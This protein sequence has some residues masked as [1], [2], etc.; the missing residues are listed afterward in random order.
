MDSS[1]GVG[2]GGAPPLRGGLGEHARARVAM[3]TEGTYPFVTGGVSTWCDQ[4]I[5]GLPEHD[6]EIVSV[7]ATDG[8]TPVWDLPD[9]V[10]AVRSVV[11]WGYRPPGKAPV[12]AARTDFLSAL[13]PFLRAVL[14][15]DVDDDTF[16]AGLM[17]L[18]DYAQEASLTAALMSDAAAELL[19][20]LWQSARGERVTVFEVLKALELLEHSLRPLSAPAISADMCHATS[21]G[22]PSL[23]ALIAKWRHGTPFIMSE[24]GVYLRERYL[25]FQDFDCPWSVKFVVL[26]FF[27]R[28]SRIAYAEAA[29]IAPVN[30]YNQRWEV[31]CG[32]DPDLIITALNGVDVDK[33]PVADGE[34]DEQ[35]VAWVGRVDPLKDLETLVDAFARLVRSQP[36]ARLDL[37]GPTPAGNESYR[38]RVDE[39]VQRRH[40]QDSVRFMGPVSPV[41]TAYH[42]SRVVVLSSISEGLPYTVIEAMMC[43]RATVSTDVGG[44]REVVGDAGLLVPPRD[45][46]ALATALEMVLTDDAL[47]HGLAARATE[48]GRSFFRLE[49]M[50]GT[51]RSE[52]AR[53]IRPQLAEFTPWPSSVDL[54]PAQR[55]DLSL[56]LNVATAVTS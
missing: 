44:V 13:R 55:S 21:N 47:R 54:V 11:L 56:D 32:A 43:G 15:S 48:R 34:P 49:Q 5:R 29:V 45:P 2:A 3:I 35:V 42:R 6:F 27:R 16:V 25:A 19:G 17:G 30:V 46:K 14:D 22:L 4:I 31:E 24:H 23:L 53:V 41:S 9:S 7:V 50:L 20:S 51:F 28:L 1:G 10:V 18:I 52:Y 39:L 33:Y 8:H 12:G 38:A 36:A 37:Y 26:S 40:L